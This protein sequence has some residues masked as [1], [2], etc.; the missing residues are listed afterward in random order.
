MILEVSERKTA[1][2]A[3]L[4]DKEESIYSQGDMQKK[5]DVEMKEE[6]E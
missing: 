6:I 5:K 4:K 3:L 1:V 2:E